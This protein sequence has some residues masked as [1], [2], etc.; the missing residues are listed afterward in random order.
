M[1]I[2]FFG[3]PEFA[4]ASLEKLIKHGCEVLAVVTSPDKPAG[5][6][7]QMQCSAVK[8]YC[9]KQGLTVLQPNNLKDETFVDALKK[10][11]ADLHIV[12][13]FR[14][15]PEQI[16]NMP[17]LGT[18]NLHASLLP[19]YRGAAPINWC[20]INGEI[21]SGVTT[22]KLQH[23]I[24]TG[25]ILLAEKV[26][27]TE[28]MT[29]GD[30]HDLL[31]QVGADL[32]LKTVR[33]IEQSLINHSALNFIS[34]QE[35]EVSH[36]P[37]LYKQHCKIDW[38]KTTQQI[39]NHIRGLSPFP[40]ATCFLNNGDNKP[41]QFK[42]LSTKLI[43]EISN[44]TNG[45]LITDNQHYMRVCCSDG[46]LELTEIQMEGKKRMGIEAFLRGFKLA[47]GAKFE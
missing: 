33:L 6:G 30:L 13:A 31:M 41:K 19:K 44:N 10:L 39:H 24:D 1:K 42:I 28:N 47:D 4:V 27:V 17:P 37:K 8:T 16:W 12:V 45:T 29:A 2:V 18:Y 36:A 14:M 26:V 9:L 40:G 38:S 35:N 15:L 32:L 23:Q 46:L 20:I 25:N 7:L 34:Q 11:N 3:T 43:H 21:E 22:F 5:R